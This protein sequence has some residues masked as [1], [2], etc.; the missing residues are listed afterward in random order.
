MIPVKHIDPD[1]LALYAMNLLPPD[2]AEEMS[3]NLQ[4]SVE[5]RRVL[6]ELRSDLSVLALSADVS[7]PS[8]HA[9]DRLM[10]QVGREMKAVQAA[11][12]PV[13]VMPDALPLRTPTIVE[14]PEPRSLASRTLPW[15]G[16]AIAA[17][18]LFEVGNLHQQG[19]RLEQIAQNSRAQVLSAE[20]R[21]AVAQTS[22]AVAASVLS[23]L[24]DPT[25]VQVALTTSGLKPPPQGRVTYVANKGSL[26]FLASNL[27]PVKPEK[28]YELWVIPADGSAPVAAGMFTPDA[29]GFA[30]VVMPTLPQGVKAKAFGV[31][32]EPTGGSSGPTAPIL[33]HGSVS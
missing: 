33:L 23:T 8:P 14:E 4:H 9:K 5:A 18:L 17:G 26:V 1:D 11:A 10:K 27:D 19:Q 24:R 3:L 20:T 7:A 28:T 21:A 22:T 15:L 30:S 6:A 2:E 16:W 25:A 13:A 29:S 31:T 12:A 32:I